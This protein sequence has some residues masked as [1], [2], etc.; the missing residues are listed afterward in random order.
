[1]TIGIHS[2][3][4]LAYRWAVFLLAAGYTVYNVLFVGWSGPGGPFRYL[5]IWALLLS[6]FAASRMLARSEHRSER[7]H[8]VTA[9]C[10]AVLNA[11]VAVLYWR[12]YLIDPGLVNGGRP[13]V[14]WQEF[15]LHAL[16]PALQIVDALLIGQVFRRIWRAVLPLSAIIAAYILWAELFVQRFNVSPSGSVTSG[17][18]YPFLNNL[19]LAERAVF[20]GTNFGVALG[21]LGAFAGL[22][23]L[24]RR[25]ARSI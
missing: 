20:Y 24:V 8:E 7:P 5:T 19:E 16:G 15:Y 11:M 4:V 10:A 21:M 25:G 1:M 13:I 14:W 2:R 6:F 17:L 12:L 9:M 3:P 18:P 23:W 22:G